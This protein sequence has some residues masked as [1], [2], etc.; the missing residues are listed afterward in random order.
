MPTFVFFGGLAAA[1]FVNLRA[2]S[3]SFPAL[4]VQENCL[5]LFF[6]PSPPMSG[7]ANMM[8]VPVYDGRAASFANYEAK[9]ALRN[10]IPAMEPRERAANLLLHMTDV[11]KEVCVA[12]GNAVIGNI[13]GAEQISRISR[14]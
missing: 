8:H 14:G 6:R 3:L 2:F 12:A 9:A 1:F 10:H 5:N 4:S 11:A 13:D 7:V